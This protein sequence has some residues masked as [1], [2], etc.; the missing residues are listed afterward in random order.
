MSTLN[1]ECVACD[2]YN[3][4]LMWCKRYLSPIPCNLDLK[5]LKCDKCKEM[6]KN[7]T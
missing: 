1:I 2:Y 7:E 3:R 6:L 5:P 4:E